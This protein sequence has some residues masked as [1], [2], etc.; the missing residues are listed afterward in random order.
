MD[1]EDIVNSILIVLIF[2]IVNIVS[3]LGIG[4]AQ[5]KKNWNDYKCMPIV[6][7][8]AGIIGPSN[9]TS[10]SVFMDCISNVQKSFISDMLGPVYTVFDKL[11]DIGQELGSFMTMANGITNG[12]KGSFLSG[13][14]GI[15]DIISKVKIGLTTMTIKFRDILNKILGIF[16]TILFVVYGSGI[17]TVS[18]WN[19]LPGQLVRDVAK[20]AGDL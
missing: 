6:I 19:G 3:I 9:V 1:S 7:P 15:F 10:A 13:S 4:L 8:F 2:A 16:L 11:N 20:A 18:L 17:T 5:I 14:M 12:F